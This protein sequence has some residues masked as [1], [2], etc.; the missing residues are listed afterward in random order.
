MVMPPSIISAK[1]FVFILVAIFFFP[2]HVSAAAISN[3]SD[4]QQTIDVE[5]LDGF[6]EVK[7]DAGR[8]W[9]VVSKTKVRYKER[10]YLLGEQEEYAIWTDGSFGPQRAN[11]R[12]GRAF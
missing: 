12:G 7:I 10:E 2:A 11:S 6:T 5:I 1:R 9:R 3:L 8:T 4:E